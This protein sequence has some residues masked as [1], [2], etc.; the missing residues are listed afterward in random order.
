[1]KKKTCI[2]LFVL[3]LVLVLSGCSGKAK[4][5]SLETEV[6]AETISDL[7]AYKSLKE[8]QIVNS[9][10]YD[11]IEEYIS[12]HPQVSVRYEIAIGNTVAWNTDEEIVLDSAD[13]DTLNA[14]F[15]YS[16][17]F[18]NLKALTINE[19]LTPEQIREIKAVCP[20]VNFSYT[21]AFAGEKVRSD[22]TVIDLSR[23]PFG[24]EVLRSAETI[25][26]L[27]P[28][29]SAVNLLRED[30][31]CGW[32]LEELA[33]LRNA[34]PENIQLKCAF[35]LFGQELSWD[36]EEIIYEKAGLSNDDLDT[37]RM[38]LPLLA[39]CK[40]FVLDNCGPSYEAL[41]ELRDEFPDKGIVW[42]VHFYADSILTDATVLWSVHVRD[43]NCHVL[44]YC[45]DLEYIDLGHDEWLTDI[46]FTANMPK[47]KVLIIG[48]TGVE[49]LSPLANCPELEYLEVFRTNVKDLS[50]LAN[51]TKLEHLNISLI[52]AKDI[53]PL[54]G[55]TELK[56]LWGIND[57]Y[58]SDAQKQEIAQI[59]PD[60]QI[61]FREGSDLTAYG[62]RKLSDGS[63]SER[64]ALLREQIGYGNYN[65]PLD[66]IDYDKSWQRGYA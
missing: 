9:D 28:K 26:E 35:T 13:Q 51:C 59:L 7:K 22:A 54:Y 52:P 30:G 55:L 20:Q 6:T 41:A 19:L 15:G 21:A 18:K 60:C 11:A 3:L 25:G 63:Y 1:M 66:K 8:L 27:F 5:E 46:S 49:D 50:P 56:R 32:S 38:A 48:I 37:V 2:I 31:S 42:R 4:L 12:D 65:S 29:V 24:E 16:H 23:K 33:A 44:D 34:L 39:G 36:R 17:Y 45:R 57:Y 61:L 58:I 64:Y 47:L 43:E 62:W 10:C 53:S 40:R 14:F